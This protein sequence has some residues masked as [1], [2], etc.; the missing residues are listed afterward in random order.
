MVLAPWVLVKYP[1]CTY[2]TITP[3]DGITGRKS[4]AHPIG[5]FV[6]KL[7]FEN[8]VSSSPKQNTKKTPRAI[9]HRVH[10][11]DPVTSKFILERKPFLV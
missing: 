2:G 10:I 9:D 7:I 5:T 6:N 11:M 1:D 3:A 8:S 4:A